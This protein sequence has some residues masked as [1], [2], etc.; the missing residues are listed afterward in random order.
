MAYTEQSSLLPTNG[1]RRNDAD[2]DS[3]LCGF[4]TCILVFVI[5]LLSVLALFSI[6]IVGPGEVGIV[7]TFGTVTSMEPGFHFRKPFVS[8][9]H[10]MSTKTQLLDQKN[11][12][13]TKEGLS[14]SL[15]TAM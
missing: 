6:T 15:E 14:V 2:I 4:C 7:V 11:T 12:I 8:V 3:M 9:L 1:N 5:V 13:P 10:K